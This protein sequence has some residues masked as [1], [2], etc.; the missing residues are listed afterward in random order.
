MPE[1]FVI[2]SYGPTLV[3]GNFTVA[4]GLGRVPY[5]FEILRQTSD[6]VWAQV[7]DSDSTNLY[8][9]CSSSGATGNLR[10]W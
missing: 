3:A 8:L 4:H 7:P 10:I 9:V 5:N 6:E 2:V 1:P